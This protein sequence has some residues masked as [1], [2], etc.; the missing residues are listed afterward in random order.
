MLMLFR[1]QTQ[2]L[3]AGIRSL[4]GIILRTAS[5]CRHEQAVLVHSWWLVPGNAYPG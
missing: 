3:G 2:I 5:R 4:H 1:R